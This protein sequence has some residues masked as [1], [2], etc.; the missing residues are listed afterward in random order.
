MRSYRRTGTIRRLAGGAEAGRAGFTLMEVLIALTMLAV[1]MTAAFSVFSSGIK[2]RS[3]TRDRMVFDRDARLLLTALSEDFANLV[4]AGPKPFVAPDRIV[5]LRLPPRVPGRVA[6]LRTPWLVTYRWSTGVE[7]DSSLVRV[8]VPLAADM[9]DSAGVA[10]EFEK[11]AG[12]PQVIGA[13]TDMMLRED[14]GSR[15]GD[16]ATYNRL[17]GAWIGYPRIRECGF[18]VTAGPEDETG[19]EQDLSRLRIRLWS[20]PAVDFDGRL[21]RYRPGPAASQTIPD[22]ETGMWVAPVKYEAGSVT[23][24]PY[25]GGQS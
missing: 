9:S 4:P 3:A 23:A 18:D 25:A 19:G 1:T 14:E 21:G 12:R 7:R 20:D 10:V 13:N 5:L 22:I 8:G 6:D 24:D 17:S 16:R 2:L 15:F 11:W